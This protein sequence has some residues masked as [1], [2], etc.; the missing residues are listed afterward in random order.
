MELQRYVKS[1]DFENLKIQVS[2]SIELFDFSFIVIC[3]YLNW[4]LH[5]RSLL[6]AATENN[7]IANHRFSVVF[8]FIG[9]QEAV[10]TRSK[11]SRSGV[12]CHLVSEGTMIIFF[13]GACESRGL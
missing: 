6:S 8:M 5:L 10:V 2:L 4:H 13:F 1:L 7:L 9:H 12:K 3:R 11:K